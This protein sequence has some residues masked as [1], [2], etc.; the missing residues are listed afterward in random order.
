MY[1]AAPINGAAAKG[2]S[3][4]EAIA[5]MEGLGKKELLPR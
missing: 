4:G 1:P 3:S 5:T 2:F